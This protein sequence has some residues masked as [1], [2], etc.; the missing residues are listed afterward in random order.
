MAICH[1][2]RKGRHIGSHWSKT[3]A[4]PLYSTSISNTRR[5]RPVADG[6]HGAHQSPTGESGAWTGGDP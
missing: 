3:V 6:V 2:A 4:P 1:D 5:S